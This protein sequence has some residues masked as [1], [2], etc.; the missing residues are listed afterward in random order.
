MRVLVTFAVEAE[1]APWRKLRGFEKMTKGKAQFFRARI[2]ASEVNVLLTGVGGKNA[3]L[4]ATKVICDG[5]VDFCISSGLAG[6]LR[7]EY[8]LGGVLAVK[9]D[10]AVGSQR[11]VGGEA[12]RDRM[13]EQR[14]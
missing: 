4:Q 9:E 12:R 11:V 13:A 3:W 6:A 1:F 2:G 5:E 14:G 7:P 10:Q 8:H